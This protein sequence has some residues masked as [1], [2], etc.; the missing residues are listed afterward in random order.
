MNR[1]FL[2]FA[3]VAIVTLLMDLAFN[4]A[5]A[6]EF[7]IAYEVVGDAPAVALDRCT[8][9]GCF[10]EGSDRF[11]PMSQIVKNLPIVAST[12]TGD[13]GLGICLLEDGHPYGTTVEAVEDYSRR[14]YQPNVA[15]LQ[16]MKVTVEERKPC[17]G[18]FT[19]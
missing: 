14:L 18:C 13:C 6:T 7:P 9:D 2:T 15:Q 1:L 11:I 5:G 10:L 17:V 3:A 8:R 16:R 19:F 4:K 12:S